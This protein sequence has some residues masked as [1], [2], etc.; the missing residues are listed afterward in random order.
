MKLS[1]KL[2]ALRL[3]AG[4]MLREHKERAAEKAAERQQQADAP[5]VTVPAWLVRATKFASWIATIS[6]MYFLWLYTLDIARDRAGALHITHAGTW[7]GEMQFWFPYVVGFAIVAFGIPYVAK[8]AIPTFMSL[9][10]RGNFWPKLWALIIALSVSL[11]VIAGT[12]AV[13]GDTLMERD[14]EA[15]V[16]VEGVQQEAA[17][18]ASRIA[19]KRAELD[20]MVNNAS[21]YVRTA[22]SMSPEAYDVFLEQRRDDWQY[23][24]LRSYRATSVDAQR[25]RG[26]I[27]ALRDQQARQTTVAA[28]Q[29]EVTTER[30]TWIADALGWLEGVRAILLSLVMDIVAL[31][32]PWIALRLEQ[33]RNRQLGMSEGIP[34][35]PWM[36]EDHSAEEPIIDLSPREAAKAVFAAGGTREEAEEAA[37]SAAR[38]KGPSLRA[39]DAETGEELVKVPEHWRRLKRGK[40]RVSTPA[41]EVDVTVNGRTFKTKG[42]PENERVGDGGLSQLATSLPGVPDVS[43]SGGRVAGPPVPAAPAAPE[44]GG[45]VNHTEQVANEEPAESPESVPVEPVHEPSEADDAAVIAAYREAEPELF[46]AEQEVDD[47]PHEQESADTNGGGEHAEILDRGG[48]AQDPADGD[49]EE[50]D[51]EEEAGED[52]QPDPREEPETR[53]ERMIAAE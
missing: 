49:E 27:A 31:M 23:D 48:E 47:R 3:R 24:R 35:H 42:A 26:E 34:R 37:R 41:G 38:P 19:D 14:R 5:N 52:H 9:S 32:M 30:T 15:A 25:L 36:I 29:G 4:A 51:R 7:I 39:T 6:L 22:A 43:D 21:V 33:T 12:F 10:W 53:P 28:V 2:E 11:V 45:D 20:D 17:V 44:H 46:A 40:Q 1:E 16:A 18:L 8:I 50:G 13:Q